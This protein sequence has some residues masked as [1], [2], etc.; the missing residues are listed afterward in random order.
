[1]TKTSIQ[2]NFRVG[3]FA[4][5]HLIEGNDELLNRVPGIGGQVAAIERAL[6]AGTD[7]TTTLHL[8]AAARGAVNGLDYP[9][10]AIS[11]RSS[12]GRRVGQLCPFFS[13]P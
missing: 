12:P 4:M 7:C 9:F 13:R 5:E 1:M 2:A 8:V 6:A 3:R 10:T 11:G